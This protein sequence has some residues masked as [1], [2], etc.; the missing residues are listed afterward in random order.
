MLCMTARSLQS[1][2]RLCGDKGLAFT[3]LRRQVYELVAAQGSP[4]SAYELLEVLKTQRTNAAPV[5]VYRALDFLL[6]AGLVHRIDALHAY[7][8]CEAE[9]A[10]HGGMLLVCDSCRNITEFENAGLERQIT[11]TALDH[12]FHTAHHLIEI[13]GLCGDCSSTTE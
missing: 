2:E 10:D 12:H 4:V 6:H 9:S 8:A 11:R 5:T 3:Q 13:R 7:T 1:A